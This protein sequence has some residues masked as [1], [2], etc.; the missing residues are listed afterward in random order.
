MTVMLATNFK[1]LSL[2]SVKPMASGQA[3]L[4]VVLVSNYKIS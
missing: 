4:L 1:V 3:Q 2:G